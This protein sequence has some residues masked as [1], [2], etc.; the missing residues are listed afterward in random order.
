MWITN[1]TREQAT[2]SEVAALYAARWEVELFFRE[3]KTVWR[4]DQIP[5][6][7]E[8]ATNCLLYA[9]MLAVIF[10]RELRHRLFDREAR[11]R[12]PLERFAR[13]VRSLLVELAT[14]MTSRATRS[15]R[16]LDRRLDWLRREA[17]DPNRRRLPAH[18]RLAGALR[19]HA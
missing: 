17:L 11:E 5:T 18:L 19:D 15:T 6:S 8:A 1:L 13:L 2:V 10:S 9:S 3:L 7:G 12:V 16:E 4:A 14:F